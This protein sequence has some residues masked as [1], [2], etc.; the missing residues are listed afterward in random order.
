MYL[1]MSVPVHF[2]T[3]NGFLIKY[4]YLSRIILN[5]GSKHNFRIFTKKCYGNTK[6]INSRSYETYI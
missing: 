4:R 5:N 2:F 1:Y 6:Q 3:D